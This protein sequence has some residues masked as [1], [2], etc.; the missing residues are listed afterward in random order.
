[1]K[2]LFPLPILVA[3]IFSVSLAVQ[4][5]RGVAF[6]QIQEPSFTPCMSLCSQGHAF[7]RWNSVSSFPTR[8]FTIQ[9]DQITIPMLLDDP[10]AYHRQIITLSGIISQPELHL[11]ES[12]LY[13]DFVF[14]LTQGSHSIVVFGR[15]DRT[16]GTL[17]ISLHQSISVMGRFWKQL[18]WK[19][20][21]L[22]N[23]IEAQ[24]L[25]PEPPLIPEA[26]S[27][28]QDPGHFLPYS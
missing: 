9:Q 1:M 12:E 10:H 7:K 19:G 22:T 13:I 21:H 18:D 15:H 5:E 8:L 25:T 26:A 17:P 14:L 23:V 28:Y 3:L 16:Q 6:S 4:S 24:L 2:R 11:D 27:L 20:S